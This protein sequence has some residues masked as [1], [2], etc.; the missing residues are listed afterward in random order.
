MA[1][2][3]N[4]RIVLNTLHSGVVSRNW[5]HL[6]VSAPP[7]TQTRSLFRREGGNRFCGIFLSVHIKLQIGSVDEIWQRARAARYEAMNNTAKWNWGVKLQ[8]A[9]LCFGYFKVFIL[10]SRALTKRC[11]Y[12]N[13]EHALVVHFAFREGQRSSHCCVVMQIHNPQARIQSFVLVMLTDSLILFDFVK[14]NISRSRGCCIVNETCS[15]IHLNKLRW[16]R[17]RVEKASDT[18][19]WYGFIFIFFAKYSLIRAVL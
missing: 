15:A 4:P 9:K 8:W 3:I 10:T 7:E 12:Q 13:P 6:S 18:S 5:S 1:A 14:L 16:N 2:N 11:E 19:T 17:G